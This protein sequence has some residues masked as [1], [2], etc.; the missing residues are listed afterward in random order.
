M[1]VTATIVREVPKLDADALG[2]GQYKEVGKS[3]ERVGTARQR[4]TIEVGG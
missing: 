4:F 2:W 1:I 3:T